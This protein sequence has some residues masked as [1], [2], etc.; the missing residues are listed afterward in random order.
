MPRDDGELVQLD[1]LGSGRLD[2]DAGRGRQGSPAPI[3]MQSLVC[4]Q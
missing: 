4:T 1:S 2:R 3:E